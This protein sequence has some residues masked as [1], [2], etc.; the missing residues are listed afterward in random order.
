MA[1]TATITEKNRPLALGHP[2]TAHVLHEVELIL[3]E[4]ATQALSPQRAHL[5][6]LMI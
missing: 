5:Y 3:K 2:T 6:K 1:A 4:R